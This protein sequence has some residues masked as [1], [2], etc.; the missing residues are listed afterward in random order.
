MSL[1]SP[2]DATRQSFA[3]LDTDGFWTNSVDLPDQWADGDAVYDLRRLDAATWEVSADGASLGVLRYA[4]QLASG[5]AATWHI[6]DPNHHTLGAGVS[7]DAWEDA[8]ASLID[9]RRQR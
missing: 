3:S 2:D 1:L 9:Y 7:W 6:G 5:E 4:P 8:V